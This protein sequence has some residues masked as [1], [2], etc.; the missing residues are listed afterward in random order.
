ME[1][2]VEASSTDW[3]IVRPPRLVDGGPPVGYR[4]KVDAL[5]ADLAIGCGIG[6]ATSGA[7]IR[8]WAGAAN[9]CAPPDAWPVGTST[10]DKTTPPPAV[11]AMA[12]ATKKMLIVR[13]NLFAAGT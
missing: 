2:L 8:A 12:V 1:R 4:V 9:A 5:P 13:L 3:T 7:L 11:A 6:C 10:S